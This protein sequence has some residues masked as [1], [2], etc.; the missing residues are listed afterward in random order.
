MRSCC[1]LVVAWRLTWPSPSRC[2]YASACQVLAWEEYNQAGCH[3]NA[4]LYPCFLCQYPHFLKREGN[5][6]QILLQR[7]KRYKNRTILGYKT[8]AAGCID[9]AEVRRGRPTGSPS[10][11]LVF[12]CFFSKHPALL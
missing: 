8:L 3:G 6:L 5:K 4:V 2:R 11:P 9:M 1:P 7:R 12:R 10:P